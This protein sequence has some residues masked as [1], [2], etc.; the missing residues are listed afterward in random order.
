MDGEH[1]QGPLEAH[2]VGLFEV[3]PERAL[4][5]H[6]GAIVGHLL[7]AL[8][9]AAHLDGGLWLKDHLPFHAGQQEA[10]LTDGDALLPG[11]GELDAHGLQYQRGEQAHDVHDELD[12]DAVRSLV[13]LDVGEEEFALSLHP[14][15][16]VLVP[17]EAGAGGVDDEG[18]GDG[19]GPQPINRHVYTTLVHADVI[20]GAVGCEGQRNALPRVRRCHSHLGCWS[21]LF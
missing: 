13:G 10:R 17:T 18:V 6:R 16:V 15:A 2:F 3:D 20:A 8:D 4:A 9:G 12:V 14:V 1:L 11:A 7:F 21:W 19:D 5:G